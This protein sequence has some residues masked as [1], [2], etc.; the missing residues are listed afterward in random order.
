MK[1][2]H[3]GIIKCSCEMFTKTKLDICS[4]SLC[5][6]EKL[7]ILP[8]L[9]AN[10]NRRA[11]ALT[12]TDLST[13]KLNMSAAGRNGC[14]PTRKRPQRSKVSNQDRIHVPLQTVFTPAT[15][16]L[17][18]ADQKTIDKGTTTNFTS[19]VSTSE[20]QPQVA[21]TQ[22]SFTSHSPFYKHGSNNNR[23]GINVPSFCFTS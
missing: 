14:H 5:I 4:H 10:I 16:H 2:N 18:T 21:S 23:Q 9:L 15:H 7:G 13:S 1:D 8:R 3:K 11:T 6:A 19:N 20:G 12:L 22:T 17:P